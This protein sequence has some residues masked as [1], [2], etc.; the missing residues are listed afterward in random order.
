VTMRSSHVQQG[1]P[2]QK[3]GATFT[4]GHG[5]HLHALQRQGPGLKRHLMQRGRPL[6]T[7]RVHRVCAM[8]SFKAVRITHWDPKGFEGLQVGHANASVWHLAVQVTCT[9]CL[10]SSHCTCSR[11][12]QLSMLSP[13]RGGAEQGAHRAGGACPHQPAPHQPRR[14]QP[15]PRPH[16][17]A[18]AAPHA[19]RRGWAPLPCMHHAS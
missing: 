6:T 8:A 19:W 16:G 2:A 3:H 18:R 13:G 12:A 10:V 17:P 9:S 1:L 15:H 5:C 14:H 11:M 4:H 7:Y